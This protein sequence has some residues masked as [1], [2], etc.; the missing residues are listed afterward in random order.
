MSL[1]IDTIAIEKSEEI[2]LIIA[3][4][5]FIKTVEDVH[6][7]LI[8]A[9]PGIKFGLAFSEASGPCLVRSSGTDSELKTLAE[10][11]SMKLACG[12]SLIIFL[13][14]CFPI[15]V[16]NALKQVSEICRIICATANPVKILRGTEDG[17]SGIMGVIDG[18]SP[19]GIEGDDDIKNRKEFLRMIGYK[20]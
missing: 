7:A 16:L 19:K 4:S 3:Q 5:H 15:N 12:H 8:T 2:N 14:D 6:E 10:K 20:L 13:K 18:F 17:N 1:I 9:V 11:N